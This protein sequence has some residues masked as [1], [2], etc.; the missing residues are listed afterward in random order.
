MQENNINPD[1]VVFIAHG[2]TQA[3]N[4]LLEG[5][6]AS[7][8]IIGMATGIDARS[9]KKETTVGNIELAPDKFLKTENAFIDSK[10]ITDE[11]IDKAIEDLLNKKSQVI[12]ASEAYSVD[13]P[14][15]ELRVMW[16]FPNHR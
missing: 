2:T 14:E 7:V 10:S 5:D 16:T 3:T 6:I 8:G 1:D 15:N 11:A 12:V 13:N 9:A 4:A